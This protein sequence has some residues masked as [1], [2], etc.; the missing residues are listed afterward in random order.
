MP[1]P[2]HIPGQRNKAAIESDQKLVQEILDGSLAAWH[3]FIDRYSGLIFGIIRRRLVME[4]EDDIRSVYVDIL[5][6]LYDGRL[7]MYRGEARLST[8]LTVYTRSR[9]F[10]FFRQ[11]HG[12]YST[13]KGLG[14]LTEFDREVL[15][16][17]YIDKLP[18][19]VIVHMLR[20]KGFSVTAETIIESIQR[21]DGL[22]DRRY[23]K[24][25]DH[26]H[27]VA[28]WGVDS[29]RMLKCLIELKLDYEEKSGRNRPDFHLIEKEVHE[30][31]ERVREQ[32]S[33]LPP[34]ERAIVFFRFN[35][36]WSAKKMAERLDLGSQRRVYS[37]I[38]R[39][40]RKLRKNIMLEE[41]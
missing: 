1:E 39:V 7:K 41:E 13:P 37:L 10:D 38:N 34:D 25:L 3:E 18:L 15:R 30:L 36:G 14:K 16:L 5:K 11:K 19:E 4:N 20:C 26:E 35:R 29:A 32:I 23:L 8:W 21:V 12:R 9:A 33:R 40:I 17:Y 28:A 27:H 31:A 6:S 24:R 22:L 2:H